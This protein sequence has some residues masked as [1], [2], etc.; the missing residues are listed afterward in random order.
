M[1]LARRPPS[2]E[3]RRYYPESYHANRA[4]RAVVDALDAEFADAPF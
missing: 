4:K 1:S 2:R 3:H